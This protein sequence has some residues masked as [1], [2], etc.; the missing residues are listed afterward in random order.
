[1]SSDVPKDLAVLPILNDTL[2][3][4][5]KLAEQTKPDK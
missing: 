4:R 5:T 3:V 2:R 1:M